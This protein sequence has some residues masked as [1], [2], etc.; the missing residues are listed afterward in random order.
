VVV[1]GFCVERDGFQPAVPV[2][3]ELTLRFSM[4]YDLKDYADVIAALDGGA[5][6]IRALV[7]DTVSLDAMPAAFEALRG[8]S[9]HCKIIVDPWT[10]F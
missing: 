4:V 6:E 1:L 5:L 7:T 3:K 10:S 9:P 2:I 8:S